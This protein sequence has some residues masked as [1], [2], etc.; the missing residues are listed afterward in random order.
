MNKLEA[1]M[2]RLLVPIATKLNAQRHVVAIRDAFILTF[3]ITMAGSMIVLINNA[4]LAPDGF[5]AKIL[6]LGDIFPNLSASQAVLAPVL[7]GSTN[8]LAVMV[9]FLIGRNLALNMKGDDLLAGLTSVSVYFIL[10]PNTVNIEGVGYLK[11]QY[12]GPQGLFVALVVGLLVGEFVTR[13][14]M[15]DKLKIT[16]PPEVPPAVSRAFAILIPIMIVTMGFSVINYVIT[17]AYPDGINALI[18]KVLQQPLTALSNN[19]GSILAFSIVSNFL[20]ILGIH[21]PNTV[22]AIREPLFA[23]AGQANL[24]W[25]NEHGTAWGAPY[26][27]TWAVNDAFANYGGSGCTLGLIIAV[28]IFSKREDYKDII[29]L[30]VA[31]GL[32]NIN[33]PII[34]GL[35]VV[36][37]P[38]LVIPFVLAP[39]INVLIGYAAIQAGII[40]P[41]AYQ[42]P[43]TTPG[44]LIAFLGTG[45]NYVALAI[46]LLCLL[47]ATVVYTPFVIAANKT[48]E[49]ENEAQ[50]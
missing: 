34:F 38:L 10:Y 23:E 2:E 43:W 17:R 14:S 5:I 29:K 37:N 48:L 33:E 1:V 21:G 9:V 24:K 41:I 8:I 15:T 13:L 25:V 6:H 11:T 31:P 7:N 40:P 50:A 4:I 20:W 47:A 26:H 22:A 3:P 42:V 18:Y 27:A 35:P 44:P 32:F 12:L 30:S 28:F 19:V 46:G 39:V 16:L 45:G 49:R 36:L